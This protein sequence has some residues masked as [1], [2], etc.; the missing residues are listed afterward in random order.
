MGGSV[1][2]AAKPAATAILG[3]V[4]RKGATGAAKGAAKGTTKAATK[5]IKGL[6]RAGGQI[7]RTAGGVHNVLK[8][9]KKIKDGVKLFKSMGMKNKEALAQGKIITQNLYKQGVKDVGKKQAFGQMTKIASKL[10]GTRA[11]N[12]QARAGEGIANVREGVAASK[13]LLTRLGARAKAAVSGG[14]RAIGS[15]IAAVGNVVEP[16]HLA[17]DYAIGRGV[18]GAGAALGAGGSIV[19]GTYIGNKLSGN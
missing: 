9:V 13:P 17:T 10:K 19:G 3:R 15:G 4:I 11:T 5:T 18:L 14:G 16:R 2:A 8:N 7:G 6:K 12:M 1:S